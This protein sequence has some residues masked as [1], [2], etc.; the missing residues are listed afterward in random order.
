MEKVN[1]NN[2]KAG[3]PFSFPA[4]FGKIFLLQVSSGWVSRMSRNKSGEKNEKGFCCFLVGPRGMKVKV[5]VESGRVG[6]LAN[7]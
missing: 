3:C 5:K 4:A 2:V 1:A 6:G 7:R